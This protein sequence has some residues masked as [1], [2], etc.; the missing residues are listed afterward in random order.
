LTI[1][2]LFGTGYGWVESGGDVNRDVTT[3]G[4]GWAQLGHVAPELGLIFPR[5]HLLALLSFRYQKVT[6]TTDLYAGGQVYEAPSSASLYL[7]KFGF[8]P[9]APRARVQPYLL[10]STGVGWIV[11]TVRVNGAANCG[12][13][14]NQQCVDAVVGG[15]MFAGGGTGVRVRLSEYFDAIAGVDVLAGA[16][17]NGTINIDFNVGVA[18]I[19]SVHPSPEWQKNPPRT[20]TN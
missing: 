14:M 3:K 4:S 18:F 13:T 20:P 1:G 17:W 8:F 15:S 7:A 12:P 16:V 2:L 10:L 19:D 11:H 9:R 5:A 6:G